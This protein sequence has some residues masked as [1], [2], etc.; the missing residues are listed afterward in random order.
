M[1]TLYPELTDEQREEAAY[2]LTQYIDLVRRIYERQRAI[3]K[4]RLTASDDPATI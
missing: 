2:Y 3:K 1:K 4:S